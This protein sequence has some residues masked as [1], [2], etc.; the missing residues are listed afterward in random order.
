[1]IGWI[2]AVFFILVTAP[3]WGG[4]SVAL[5]S[6]AVVFAI[7]VICFHLAVG[8]F[9]AINVV[10]QFSET[11]LGFADVLSITFQKIVLAIIATFVRFWDWVTILP[12]W[13]W[14]FAR[15]DHPWWAFFIG[16]IFIKI[17]DWILN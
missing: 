13:F 11:H 6:L 3:L 7:I 16:L 5:A 9:A 17:W 4:G 10:V 12:E 15:Y 2:N 1:M 8:A 14:D